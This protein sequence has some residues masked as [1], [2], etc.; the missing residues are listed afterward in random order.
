[1]SSISVIDQ[2]S[3]TFLF[4]FVYILF[5]INLNVI[6]KIMLHFSKGKTQI[7]LKNILVDINYVTQDLIQT[8]KTVKVYK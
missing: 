3:L 2:V 1:M 7:I 6:N 4:F 5:C 8:I